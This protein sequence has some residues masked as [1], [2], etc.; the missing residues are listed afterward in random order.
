MTHNVDA[1][2]RRVDAGLL[3]R[4]DVYDAAELVEL[5]V[6]EYLPALAP[7]RVRV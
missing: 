4:R 2:P 7:A 5:G 1:A 6:E 3:G